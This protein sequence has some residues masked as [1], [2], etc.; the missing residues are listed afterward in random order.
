VTVTEAPSRVLVVD[1]DPTVS[2]VVARYLERDGYTVETVADGRTALDR[3]LAEPPDL[4]V[5]DLMLPGIDGLEVCRRLRALAPVPIVI[6][7]ARGQENDRIVGLDLGADD[8]VAKPFSTKE[9]VARVRAVL[10]RARGPLAPSGPDAPSVYADGDLEVDVAARQ[11]RL[12]GAVVSL[13]AREFE[14]LAFLV[15]HPG[16]AFRREELLEG[17]WG[18]R[19]GDTSTVTVHVRR[20][21]EKIEP[22]PS[23]PV[24]IATVWGV[25][26]RWEGVDAA[27]RP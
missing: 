16:R 22:D 11:A 14:L 12:A 3:A 10:R 8:Y 13:T 5:L 7:T 19:Y 27:V 18:Y 17:V 20:L 15:R 24:R 2:E 4:V 1:D 6:L 25:G 21:R 26:Y 23:A 9:L